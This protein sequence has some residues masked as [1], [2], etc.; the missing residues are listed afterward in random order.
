MEKTKY[1]LI[2]TKS[3]EGYNISEEQ[4]GFTDFEIIGSLI[5][6]IDKKKKAL[7]DGFTKQG[8]LKDES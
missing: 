2:V 4:D 1:T 8:T 3:D 6:I 5:H 7:Y